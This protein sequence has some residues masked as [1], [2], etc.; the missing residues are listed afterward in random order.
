MAL[1]G[2]INMLR[3]KTSVI[4][5]VCAVA[6][7]YFFITFLTYCAGFQTSIEKP[8]PKSI[9]ENT[10]S[11][12]IHSKV[13]KRTVLYRRA[14]GELDFLVLP[15]IVCYECDSGRTFCKDIL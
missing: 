12:Y 1:V 3:L 13:D 9:E 11:C 14:N 4:Y 6:L 5:G 2:G 15:D 7:F 8:K 10:V